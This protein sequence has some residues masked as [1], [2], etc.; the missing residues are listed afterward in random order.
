MPQTL[1]LFT[2]EVRAH[3]DLS[4]EFYRLFLDSNMVYSSAVYETDHDTLE[5]AQIRK[6]DQAFRRAGIQRGQRVVDVGFGWGAAVRRLA[7]NYGCHAI[8][9]T[10][11]Q[12][13]YQH[14]E[15]EMTNHPVTA[16][17]VELRMQGWEQFDEPVDA[18]VS[19]EVMEH[20]RHE[21]Y[22]AFF[23]RC[24]QILPRG[25]RALIQVNAWSDPDYCKEVGVE[26]D[27]ESVQFAKFIRQE[28]FPNAMLP[29]PK[30]V[31]RHAERA[32]F[33]TIH[34]ISLREHYFRTLDEWAANLRANKETAIEL[35]GNKRYHAYMH[36]LTGCSR[37]FSLGHIDVPQFTFEAA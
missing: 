32:G 17:V 37:Y 21:R 22:Q 11:S 35:V 9:L 26:A 3:Y 31:I 18:V 27:A 12:A 13:Q 24:R 34:H 8:G 23:D 2:Q 7:E 6:L 15:Q 1:R 19:F 30:Q 16:G 20:F 29:H 28:I 33:K 5:I 14:V 4:N 10:L 25:G 36:Y